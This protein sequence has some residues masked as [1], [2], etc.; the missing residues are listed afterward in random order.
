M[1]LKFLIGTHI[2]HFYWGIMIFYVKISIYKLKFSKKIVLAFLLVSSVAYS[3]KFI[4]VSDIIKRRVPWLSSHIE[5]DSI[6]KENEKD[7]FILQTKNNKIHIA[8][9]G[10]NAAAT[11]L[12]WYLKYYCNRSMSHLGDNLSALKKIPQITQSVKQVSQ[13]QYRYALNYCTI[14]YTMSFYT[15]KDWERELDWMA[16]H[17]VN[18]LLVP[19]GTEEV[20]QNTLKQFQFTKKEIEDFIPG[21]AF[22]AWWL[23]GNLEGWGGSI[24]QNMIKQQTVLQ[25]KILKRAKQL[26]IQ[27]IL[28]SFY[29]M[30]PTR[31]KNKIKAKITIQG[32]WAGDFIRPD[33]LS[34]EDSLFIRMSDVYY[35]EMKKLYGSDIKYFGGEPFHEGGS[36][37]GIDVAVSAKIIQQ[38][39]QKHFPSSTWVLQ[40][41][42][43]N[44]SKELLGGLN[45]KNI[46]VIELFGENT[47]NWEQRNGY[48]QT[49]FIWSSVN[50]FGEKVGLY[51][52]LERF[53]AEVYRTKN[54]QYAHLLKGVGI[55]PE[56][57]NNNP[58]VFDLILELAWQKDSID[59]NKWIQGYVKARYGIT[60]QHLSEAWQLLLKTVYNSTTVRVEGN[61]ESI[62]C[63]RP[64]LN[65]QSVSTWGSITKRYDT[66]LFAIAVNKFLLAEKQ[67]K[68]S[69]T[70]QTDK[71]DM[72]RQLNAN[73]ADVWYAQ[74]VNDVKQK[75][76]QAFKK[77]YSA[78][79]KL[80]LR[81]DSL[82]QQ[83]HFFTLKNWLKQ[84]KRFATNTTDKKLALENAKAQITYWG[85]NNPTTN[86]HDYANK[87]WGGL[88]KDFY[89][90][91]WDMFY[92]YTL[93]QLQGKNVKPEYFDFEKKWTGSVLTKQY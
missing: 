22:T 30:V 70:Y 53:A 32:K 1:E 52:K 90:K 86:L 3:Q 76:E 93:Q 61:P 2:I 85:P 31:L 89:L 35:T 51:G 66:S 65:V 42:G 92:E 41:W 38:Q 88:L 50:N 79:R 36:S 40:G 75:D 69:V 80:L 77:S 49:P 60:N 54:S 13:V 23:M 37:K 45:K 28:Q 72:L 16:L 20:W 18:L 11:G 17:G 33:F 91:R 64:S 25:Q 29:G 83:N 39:M 19:I 87:E 5:F 21:P 71:T 58:V 67:L 6:D 63:A 46:L 10:A 44:P 8:A 14:N 57:I 12:Q 59:V 9:S 48:E 68:S 73:S 4:S 56:G 84:A 62:F 81:Q 34:P 78:F 74:M 24:S 43:G 15:W 47:N 27:P 26:G 7:V 55:I 82:L